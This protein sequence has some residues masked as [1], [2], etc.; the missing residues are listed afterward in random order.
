[1]LQWPR[2]IPIDGAP[3]DVVAVVEQYDAWLAGGPGI[4]ALW[5]TFDGSGL[6]TPA[7]VDWARTTMP[8]LEHVALGRAGHH[9]PEDVPDQITAAIL[10]WLDRSGL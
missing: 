2:E 10:A 5:L 1:M 6:S 8:T 4:P 7:L 9:A 3:A